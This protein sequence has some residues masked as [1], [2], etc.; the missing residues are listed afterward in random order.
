MIID[1]G[2]MFIGDGQGNWKSFG[3]IGPIEFTGMHIEGDPHPPK[4]KSVEVPVTIKCEL[5]KINEINYDDGESEIE[6]RMKIPDNAIK[7]LETGVP[8]FL[9]EDRK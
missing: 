5:E 4:F 9:D 7:Y 3:K 1:D 2:E 8:E 6:Y